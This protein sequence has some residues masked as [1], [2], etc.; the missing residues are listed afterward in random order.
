[1]DFAF[2]DHSADVMP[3]LVD[4]YDTH[5]LYELARN[6]NPEA[7]AELAAAI[8]I[9]LEKQLSAQE[10][11]LIADIMIELMRK[12]AVDLRKAVAERLAQ[13]EKVPLRLLLHLANDEIDVADIIL[14]QSPLLCDLDLIYIIKSKDADYWRAIAKR[15]NLSGKLMGI[16][17]ESGDVGTAL[18]LIE[19]TAIKLT[20]HVLNLFCDLAQKNLNLAPPL[21]MR[22]EITAPMAAKLYAFVGKDL[23][24][25]IKERFDLTPDETSAAIE[26]IDSVLKEMSQSL[27]ES[28]TAPSLDMI[29]A[30]KASK[31]K[32]PP[33]LADMLK[34]LQRGQLQSFVAQFS[35]YADMDVSLLVSVLLQDSGQGLAVVCR[36]LNMV[37]SD[38][39][40]IYLLTSRIRNKD[41]MVDPKKMTRAVNY[42]NE[43]TPELARDILSL[44]DREPSL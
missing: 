5:R 31:E 3:L 37:K 13:S 20:P 22:D 16:L 11:E 36:A 19:N 43:I 39:M 26:E 6:K 18:N 40:S 9:L 21:L 10:S 27:E 33:N 41:V 38:F 24:A 35:V 17:A 29:E 2:L 1:M 7:K 23:K 14:R 8:G 28:N 4:V 44:S 15:A 34:I 42:F 25:Q 30:A 32:A 12:A